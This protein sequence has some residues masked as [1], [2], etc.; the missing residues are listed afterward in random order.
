[1]SATASQ[2]TGASIVCTTVFSGADQRKHQSSAPLA[3]VR[4]IHRWPVNSLHKGPGTQKVFPFDDVIMINSAWQWLSVSMDRQ[5]KATVW[6]CVLFELLYIFY[7]TGGVL[8]NSQIVVMMTSS[9]GDIFRVTGHLCGEFIGH[10]WIPHT[11]A[12]DTEL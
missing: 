2:I 11:K 12:R 1:M 7:S 10:W 6:I 4:G 5:R 3:F 9:N 8:S